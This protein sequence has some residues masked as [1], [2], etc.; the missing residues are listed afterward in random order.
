MIVLQLLLLLLLLLAQV[1]LRFDNAWR[2]CSL[3]T[4]TAPC[5][6]ETAASCRRFPARVLLVSDNVIALAVVAVV[7]VLVLPKTHSKI[8]ESWKYKCNFSFQHTFAK[9]LPEIEWK[10]DR[11]STAVATAAT[12][13]A[14]AGGRGSRSGGGITQRFYVL[15]GAYVPLRFILWSLNA[16]AIFTRRETAMPIPS[17]LTIQCVGR[18]RSGGA[19]S[20]LT[21]SKI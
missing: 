3:A 9:V 11:S 7:A 5:W 1:A 15:L 19:A 10:K 6:A 8:I 4:P 18:G 20:N 14:A 16:C 13:A 17:Q 12:N 2:M 21:I